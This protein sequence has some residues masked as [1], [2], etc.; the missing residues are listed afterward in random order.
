MQESG[1]FEIHEVMETAAMYCSFYQM[2]YLLYL[3]LLSEFLLEP[4][5]IDS[6][7]NNILIDS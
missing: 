5:E 7:E 6:A 1:S 4:C 3:P 2:I